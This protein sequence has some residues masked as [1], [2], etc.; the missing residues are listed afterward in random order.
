MGRISTENGPKGWRRCPNGH[1]MIIIGFE[2]SIQGQRR[3]VVDDLVGGHALNN[4]TDSEGKVWRW[5]DESQQ[6]HAETTS[7]AVNGRSSNGSIPHPNDVTAGRYPPS[8]GV[9]MRVRALWSYWPQEGAEDEL[10]FPK[11]A[12]IRECEDI[13]GDWI[14]GIYCGRKG[15]FPGNYCWN[16]EW[17]KM[18]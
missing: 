8:G 13:N 17:D 1:R 10:A 11:G 14:L 6:T 16:V 12:E 9:G 18:T 7:T 3:I 5:R 2:D 15:I 4:T